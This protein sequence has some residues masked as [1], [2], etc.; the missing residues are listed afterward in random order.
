MI[1]H[2][3]AGHV[4]DLPAADLAA[5]HVEKV[6]LDGPA[7]RRR[8]Q[9]VTT[10]HGREIGLR[11]S[12]RV[13]LRDGDILLQEEDGIVVVEVTPSDVLMIAPADVREALEVAHTLGNRHLPAQ[14]LDADVEVPGL[15]GHSGV[16]VVEYDHTV[17]D[18]LR[19]AGIR[20][21]RVERAMERPFRHAEHTH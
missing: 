5:T 17:V 1:V 20:A 21:I 9:R 18:H 4:S 6:R 16:M 14:F 15:P 3:L 19:S 7:L 12:G 13:E 8:I 11:L 10:D 2:E